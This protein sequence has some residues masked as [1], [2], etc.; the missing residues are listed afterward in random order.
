MQPI[1]LSCTSCF[2]K[3]ASVFMHALIEYV[4]NDNRF[5]LSQH[6][7]LYW[8]EQKTLI[9][10]DLHLTKAG[11][12][13]FSGEAEPVPSFREQIGRLFTEILFFKAEQLIITGEFTYSY[14]GR[15]MELFEKRRNDF[16]LLNIWVAGN[17]LPKQDDSFF[18]VLRITRTP[19]L[20]LGKFS[21]CHCP[22]DDKPHE[23]L[24][25][26]YTFCGGQHP[27][28]TKRGRGRQVLKLPCFYF[29]RHYAVLPS[30]SRFVPLL[31]VA[32]LREENVFS[33]TESG[34]LQVQ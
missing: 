7:S 17:G 1:L 15:E 18:D 5:I 3:F 2:I 29:R 22:A 25:Q 28:I 13:R 9:V 23:L 31:P 30:F 32:P 24:Q 33:I 10:A 21:F 20:N 4:I 12:L 16:P 8:K 19:R 34:L 26:V 6:R 14:S 11:Y 27:A